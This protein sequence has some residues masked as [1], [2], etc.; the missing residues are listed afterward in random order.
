MV[1]HPDA[2]H[3]E[4]DRK[5]PSQPERGEGDKGPEGDKGAY[6]ERE[7]AQGEAA[8]R[9]RDRDRDDIDQVDERG[10]HADP[11]SAQTELCESVV[12]QANPEGVDREQD[13]E[14]DLERD[15][16]R[17]REHHDVLE[18]PSWRHLLQFQVLP[19][20]TV[21]GSKPCPD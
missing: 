21:L 18:P 7:K 19:K 9:D 4:N 11:S 1:L 17:E 3:R 15:R 14:R 8:D 12:D 10:D 20:I 13:R 2:T 5:I 16:G 6:R